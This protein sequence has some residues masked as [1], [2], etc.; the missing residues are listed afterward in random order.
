MITVPR[1]RFFPLSIPVR[2]FVFFRALLSIL[3]LVLMIDTVRILLFISLA[4]GGFLFCH[5]VA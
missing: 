5:F 3:R 2:L 1:F 4:F